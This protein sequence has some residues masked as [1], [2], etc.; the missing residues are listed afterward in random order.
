MSSGQT[1]NPCICCQQ[2]LVVQM[3][4]RQRGGAASLIGCSEITSPSTPPRKFRRGDAAGTTVTDSWNSPGCSGPPDGT[5][6]CV[7]DGRFIQYDAATGVP[8]EGGWQVCNGVNNFFGLTCVSPCPTN[9]C[10]ATWG[11]TPT[12]AARSTTGACCPIGGGVFDKGRSDSLTYTFSDEDLETD[13]IA[14]LLAGAGGTWGAWI[15]TG[16]GAGGTCL[17]Q[18]CCLAQWGT[19]TTGFSFAYNEDQFQIVSIPGSLAPLTNYIIKVQIFRRVASSPAPFDLFETL[20]FPITTD[21]AGNF[22]TFEGDVPNDEGFQ[23]YSGAAFAVVA[24]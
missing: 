10:L 14:R 18:S 8:T 19:R 1:E 9:D 12:T 11:C 4:C 16:N 22:A 5:V 23:T 17:P 20:E 21:G 7:N 15:E 2:H 13:A 3:N 24:P 6:T